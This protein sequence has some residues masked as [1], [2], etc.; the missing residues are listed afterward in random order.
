M[1]FLLIPIL[2]DFDIVEL[3][4]IPSVDIER[5]KS[6]AFEKRMDLKALEKEIQAKRYSYR[7]ILAENLPQISAFAS[8]SLNDR[9][10]PFGGDGSGYLWV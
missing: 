7:S 6:L 1:K 10:N 4:E 5:I 3:K 8:F 2:G 9:D